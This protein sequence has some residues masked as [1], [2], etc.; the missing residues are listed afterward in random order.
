MLT[1]GSATL[2]HSC[3]GMQ[4]GAQ[5]WTYAATSVQPQEKSPLPPP[6]L[7]P[8][9]PPPGTHSLSAVQLQC[10]AAHAA[11]SLKLLFEQA[12]GAMHS[13]APWASSQHLVAGAAHVFP[14]Q[15]LPWQHRQH[16]LLQ[17][18][19]PSA[20]MPVRLLR[21]AGRGAPTCPRPA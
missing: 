17:Q 12:P 8:R 18:P 5:E 20:G 13:L 16:S 1:V 15:L 10:A 4:S 6:P 2:A 7:P 14:Q 11:L 21:Q 3:H 9:P 19:R